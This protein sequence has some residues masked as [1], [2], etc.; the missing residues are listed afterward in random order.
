MMDVSGRC[1]S[2]TSLDWLPEKKVREGKQTEETFVGNTDGVETR[3]EEPWRS[4]KVTVA[5]KGAVFVQ[6]NYFI[7]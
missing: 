6:G 5:L 3:Q 2:C 7:S 4:S 1:F